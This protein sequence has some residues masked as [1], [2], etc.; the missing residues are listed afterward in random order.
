M[1]KKLFVIKGIPISFIAYDGKEG[2]EM[3][4]ASSPKPDVILLDNRLPAKNGIVVAREIKSI[5]PGVRIIFLSADSQVEKEAIESGANAFLKK[6]SS[7]KAILK[8]IELASNSPAQ[9]VIKT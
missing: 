1:L 3:F 8:A 2:V 5:D 9:P 6:P 4:Q 7:L